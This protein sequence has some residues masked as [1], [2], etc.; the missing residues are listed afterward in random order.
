M[1]DKYIIE[2]QSTKN[3]VEAG[4]TTGYQVGIRIPYYRGLGISMI[5]DITLKIDD[6]PIPKED[7]VVNLHGHHYHLKEM[8]S[9]PDDRWEFGEIGLATVRHAGGLSK[10][11]H[12]VNVSVQLRISYMPVP[13]LTHCSKSVAFN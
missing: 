4:K 2:E 11:K 7:I 13:S 6:Q 3:I 8:E 12:Q 9:E 1:F 5:E 10:G